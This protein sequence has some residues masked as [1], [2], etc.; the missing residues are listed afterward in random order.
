VR[1]IRSD[2]RV[3]LSL[4]TDTRNTMGLNEYHVVYGTARVTEGGHR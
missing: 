4:E 3:A 1:N 2:S